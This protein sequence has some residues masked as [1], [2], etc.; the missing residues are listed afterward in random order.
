MTDQDRDANSSPELTRQQREVLSAYINAAEPLD[1]YNVV[2][3]LLPKEPQI[4]WG[5]SGRQEYQAWLRRRN[6]LQK[7][8]NLLEVG[9]LII[10]VSDHPGLYVV[11]DVGRA[12]LVEEGAD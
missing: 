5:G 6:A 12:A 4:G 11:S 9:G 1:W 3:S 10:E 7:A 8:A 2:E